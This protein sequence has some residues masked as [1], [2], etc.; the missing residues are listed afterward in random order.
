MPAVERATLNFA[1]VRARRSSPAFGGD[2]LRRRNVP[3]GS[4]AATP[5]RARGGSG[6]AR[7]TRH[8]RIRTPLSFG[9]PPSRCAKR[10]SAKLAS[11]PGPHEKAPPDR[12]GAGRDHHHGGHTVQCPVYTAEIGRS[13]HWS[14]SRHWLLFVIW[15]VEQHGA[16]SLRGPFSHLETPHGDARDVE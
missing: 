12:R 15:L 7:A 1:R 9:P 16:S 10:G 11:T 4:R 14:S 6:R 3:R 2:A 8:D 5:P 13:F